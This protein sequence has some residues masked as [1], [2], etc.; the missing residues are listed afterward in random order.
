[1]DKG[2]VS[3][4]WGVISRDPACDDLG[5]GVASGHMTVPLVC[6]VRTRLG[7]PAVQQLVQSLLQPWSLMLMSGSGQLEGNQPRKHPNTSKV[8]KYFKLKPNHLLV[9]SLRTM[10]LACHSSSTAMNEHLYLFKCDCTHVL[11]SNTLF[12]LF[13]YNYSSTSGFV[14]VYC[15]M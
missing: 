15:L 13:T 2:P 10:K 1:M 14:N 9:C 7:R 6:L 12:I 4:T 11:V 3:S 8:W 5:A